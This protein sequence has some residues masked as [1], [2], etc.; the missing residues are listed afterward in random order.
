M[1]TR[2]SQIT[3]NFL[4]ENS[5]EFA[6]FASTSLGNT[7]GVIVSHILVAG[8]RSRENALKAS[9]VNRVAFLSE[10]AVTRFLCPGGTSESFIFLRKFSSGATA[11]RS[12][13]FQTCCIADF[14]IGG[15]CDVVPP[16]GLETRDTAQRGEAATNMIQ[17]RMNTD[18]HG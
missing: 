18:G 3:P 14:Q 16:A 12:A 2:I 13:G 17:P 5:R 7:V 6:Q 4:Q 1:L 11:R 10:K 15:A 8:H 9:L